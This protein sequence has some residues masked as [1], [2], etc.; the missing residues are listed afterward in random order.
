MDLPPQP[1]DA[2]GAIAR[3]CELLI[4]G[5]EPDLASMSSARVALDLV[6][7]WGIS[8]SLVS[9]VIVVQGKSANTLSPKDIRSQLTCETIGIVTMA[10]EALVAAQDRAVPLVLYLPTHVATSSFIE[11]AKRLTAP[12]LIGIRSKRLSEKVRCG[13]T[14]AP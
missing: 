8:L 1:S 9:G 12:T 11:T 14:G 13:P 4:L 6:K 2:N 10:A 3:C 7:S 5:L